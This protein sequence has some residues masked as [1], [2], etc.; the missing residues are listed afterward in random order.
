MQMTLKLRSALLAAVGM[1][2]FSAWWSAAHA[3]QQRWVIDSKASLAWW[4]MNPTLGH[5]WGTTCPDEP[6]WRAGE[7]STIDQI[8]HV[9][10]KRTSLSGGD[11]NRIPLYPR[12]TVRS[13]CR[14]SLTGTITVADTTNSR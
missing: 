2:L 1:T 10:N 9:V 13:L 12:K 6:S 4:Q 5:L 7:G 3:Q 14:T 8:G 11:E